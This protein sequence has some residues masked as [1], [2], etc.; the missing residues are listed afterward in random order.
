MPINTSNVDLV[1]QYSLLVAGDHY[2]YVDREF[3]SI[4]IIEYVYLADLS[5]AKC[6][7]GHSFTGINWLLNEFGP[8]SQEV[9]ARIEPALN[10]IHANKIQFSGNNG[11]K[12]DC[13]RWDLRNDSLLDEKRCALPSVI[14]THLERDIHQF[15]NDTT[16]LLDYVNK[17]KPIISAVPNEYLDLSLVVENT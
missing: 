17:T 15:G 16:S 4:H 1:I 3:G 9:H 7:N 11:D 2:N 8:W 6:N 5:Y 10:A 13:I 14:M 12:E